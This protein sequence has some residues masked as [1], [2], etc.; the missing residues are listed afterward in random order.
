M[1]SIIALILALMPFLSLSPLIF[2]EM[3]G[4]RFG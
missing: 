3:V 2:G 1:P 4:M